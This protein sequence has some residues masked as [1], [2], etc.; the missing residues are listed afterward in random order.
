MNIPEK[1]RVHLANKGGKY[2]MRSV[3]AQQ[4]FCS[5]AEFARIPISNLARALILKSG[6]AYL[7]VVI[8]AD[9]A[10]DMGKL[11]TMFKREFTVCGEEDTRCLLPDGDPAWFPPL[12]EP[13][14]LRAVIDKS[15]MKLDEVFFAAGVAGHFI[16][17]SKGEFARIQEDAWSNFGISLKASEELPD[18]KSKLKKRVESVDNLPAMPGLA[19]EIVRI[20]NNPYSNASELAAVIEQDPSL[21]AQLMRYALSP[22]YGYQGKVK[23]V[24][25]AIV[26][27]LGMD[28]VFDIAFGLSLGKTFNNPKE[29]PLGLRDF[30]NHAIHCAALTQTLCKVIDYNRRP[31]SGVAYLAGLLH[32]FGFLLLGHLFPDQF[33]RL[34]LAVMAQPERSI[35]EIEREEIGV[36]HCDLGLWLMDAWDMPTEIIE[37]IQHHHDPSFQGDYAIYANLVYIANSLLKRHGI[38]DSDTVQ[39]PDELLQRVGLDNFKLDVALRNVLEDS[40]GLNYMAT[41]MAA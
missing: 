27:V 21:S 24:E 37:T 36:T 38:G 9:K 13:F 26:R 5:T 35:I 39:I 16:R 23:S 1:V 2:G 30:W 6:K 3:Q 8:A 33:K 40:E 10:L 17:A 19:T 7:M 28:F 20:R 25:Q 11:N 4:D 34:N 29:G 32:N 14:G 41:K 22:L 18:E 12:A 15:L 31:S